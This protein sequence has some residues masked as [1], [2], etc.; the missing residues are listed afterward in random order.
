MGCR[1]LS[2]N[3]KRRNRI[4][5]GTKI[6]VRMKMD[7]VCRLRV[8]PVLSP[9]WSLVGWHLV[10]SSARLM[11]TDVV[12]N[13]LVSQGVLSVICFWL[14]SLLNGCRLVFASRPVI[15]R[16]FGI[17]R[18]YFLRWWWSLRCQS[19]VVLVVIWIIRRAPVVL[20]EGR[21]GMSSLKLHCCHT[22]THTPAGHHNR[23]LCKLVNVGGL[24]HFSF[25]LPALVSYF[26]LPLFLVWYLAVWQC[27]LL[28]LV[29]ILGW[30]SCAHADLTYEFSVVLVSIVRVLLFLSCSEL[31]NLFTR[32]KTFRLSQ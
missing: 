14:L 6:C 2:L 32:D 11:E 10:F 7:G 22:R 15:W 23:S 20:S 27:T 28:S 31:S 1:F 25:D 3:S 12:F 5:S 9:C 17:I 30:M 29:A 4:K 26:V 18:V 16:S 19:S 8:C 13:K 21:R 24:F